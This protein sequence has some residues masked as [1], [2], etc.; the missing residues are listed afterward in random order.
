MGA[1]RSQ[2]ESDLARTHYHLGALCAARGD[3]EAAQREY[4]RAI[5]LDSEG[6][7]RQRAEK[8]LEDQPAT[9]RQ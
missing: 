4:Q 9:P 2:K 5:D 6:F 7:Y 3:V 1:L 8:A